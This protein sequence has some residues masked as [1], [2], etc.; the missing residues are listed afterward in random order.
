MMAKPM[1]TL[2]LHYLMI[3]YLIKDNIICSKLRLKFSFFFQKDVTFANVYNGTPNV[4]VS[5]DHSSKGGN[6]SPVHNAITAWV[7]VRQQIHIVFFHK[8]KILLI[9]PPPI[10]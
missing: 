6:L 1:K 2:E 10:D 5:A 4:F 3:Q 7:E 9:S 8:T